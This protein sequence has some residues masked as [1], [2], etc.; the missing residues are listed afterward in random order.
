VSDVD[1]V[2][3]AAHAYEDALAAGDAVAATACFDTERST[4]RFGPDGS[5]LDLD[6]VR[7]LRASSAPTPVATWLHDDARLLAPG[8]VLHLAVLDRGGRTIQRTQVWVRRTD[9]WRI[10]HAHVSNPQE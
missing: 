1:E 4:S 2:L 9:G 10:T 6:A 7:A 3:A 8:V 5:Q